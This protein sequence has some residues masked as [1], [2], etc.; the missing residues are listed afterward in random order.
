MSYLNK[1]DIELISN[2]KSL[3]P[4]ADDRFIN[5]MFHNIRGKQSIFS[6]DDMNDDS[7][8]DTNYFGVSD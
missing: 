6:V 1:K 7:I 8:S 4:D 5:A 2:I 3:F